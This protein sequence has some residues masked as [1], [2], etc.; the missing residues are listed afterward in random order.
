MTTNFGFT[1]CPYYSVGDAA[2]VPASTPIVDV[3]LY[4]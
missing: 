1:H 3:V 2:Y 4:L